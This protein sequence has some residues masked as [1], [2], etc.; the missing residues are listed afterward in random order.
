MTLAWDQV[1]DSSGYDDRRRAI[2][3]F[4]DEHPHAKRGLAI[5]PV[6][7][8]ISFNF[9]AFNQAGA[10]VHVYADGSVLVS[11]GGTRRRIRAG[12]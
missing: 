1:R 4:N 3:A 7:F 10:L 8:G 9:T 2:Q 11:H 6:K 5:T 12:R